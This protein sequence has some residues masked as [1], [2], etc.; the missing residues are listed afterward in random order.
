MEWMG[1]VIESKCQMP[2][3]GLIGHDRVG[4]DSAQWDK[5]HL[6]WTDCAGREPS[7]A[8]SPLGL[9]VRFMLVRLQLVSVHCCRIILQKHLTTEILNPSGSGITK[10]PQV[11]MNEWNR[12]RRV[13]TSTLSTSPRHIDPSE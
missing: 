6:N 12:R 13:Y 3:H 8:F 9:H 7:S 11:H 4:M 1:E 10:S 5:E 2:H